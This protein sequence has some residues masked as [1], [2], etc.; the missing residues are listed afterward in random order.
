LSAALSVAAYLASIAVTSTS[1]AILGH[2]NWLTT[3]NVEAGW[4]ATESL[5]T[6][7]QCVLKKPNIRSVGHYSHNIV[8][9][10]ALHIEQFL[11][12]HV[13]VSAL[14]HKIALVNDFAITLA[15]AAL[16]RRIQPALKYI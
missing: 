3:R 4:S 13:S 10:R 9:R 14:L 16:V 5:G 7:F 15:L 11:D 6:A 2:A 8:H 1:I 12:F